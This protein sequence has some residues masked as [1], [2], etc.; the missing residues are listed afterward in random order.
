MKGRWIVG[1][2][3][4]I[5]AVA[6]CSQSVVEATSAS[7]AS[8]AGGATTAG[9]TT[10]ASTTGSGGASATSAGSTTGTGTTIGA[11]GAVSCAANQLC[12]HPAC[13]NVAGEECIIPE[14]PDAG[15]VCP[16][17]TVREPQFDSDCSQSGYACVSGCPPQPPFCLD[18][19]ASCGGV[20][21]CDCLDKDPC[22]STNSG[23]CHDKDI[24]AGALFCSLQP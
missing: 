8:S 9:G 20:A 15:E 7:G 16:P 18:L 5:A 21:S 1:N 12:V 4:L 23:A 2:L 22:L 13:T 19:P 3:A 6:A 14:M 17:G 10:A 11:C 24:S